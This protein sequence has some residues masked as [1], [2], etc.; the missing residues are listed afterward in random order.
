MDSFLDIAAA[1]VMCWLIYRSDL[2][3]NICL[4]ITKG[5]M[6]TDIFISGQEISSLKT[7]VLGSAWYTIPK[8]IIHTM[9]VILA[10]DSGSTI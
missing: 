10:E 8:D 6:S 4:T 2:L 7:P 3:L 5:F 9:T 1:L